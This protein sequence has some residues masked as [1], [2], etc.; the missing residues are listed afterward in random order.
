MEPGAIVRA[1]AGDHR[2]LARGTP[3]AGQHL[4]RPALLHR[5]EEV[6]RV[7]RLVGKDHIIVAV[8]VDVHET[9]AVVLALGVDEARAGR[10][11]ERQLRPGSSL[12]SPGK[13]R[14]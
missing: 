9:Q 5:L 4:A 12:G 11:R 14:L 7:T 3:L 2:Q 10:K 1:A 8:L 13:Y 6:D